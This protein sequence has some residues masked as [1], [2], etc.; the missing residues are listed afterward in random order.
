MPAKMKKPATPVG[1]PGN[2][3]ETGWVTRR[4]TYDEARDEYI[5]PLGESLS[6]WRAWPNPYGKYRVWLK[7]QAAVTVFDFAVKDGREHPDI[8]EPRRGY[9]R[10]V[11]RENHEISHVAR[12]KIA[13][14]VFLP[15][16]D[17]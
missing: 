1:W 4:F 14:A 2:P 15:C 8:V 16:G 3:P 9:A 6:Y 11:V 7:I 12:E 5:C 10:N 17:G 13:A